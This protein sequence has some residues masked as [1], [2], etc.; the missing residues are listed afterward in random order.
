MIDLFIEPLQYPFMLKALLVAVTIS[1]VCGILSC[2]LIL[3]S[4]SLMGD[5]ISHAILPGIIIAYVINIPMSIGAFAS[6]LLCSL[7]IGYVKEKSRLKEDTV[8]GVVFSGFF[9]IG[10]ILFVQIK[11]DKHLD[12]I[13]LGNILG[14]TDVDMVQTLII[15]VLTF[16]VVLLKRKDFLLYCFDPIH[17]K[18]SGLSVRFTHY[19]LLSLLTITIVATIQSVGIILV[20]AMLVTPGITAFALSKNFSSMLII[21]IL[22]SILASIIGVIASF[23]LDSSTGPTIVLVQS[24]LFILSTIYIKTKKV[25]LKNDIT[26]LS[27]K[28]R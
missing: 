28:R 14:I 4:W 8:M 27:F 2:F 15:S 19:L 23:H 20:V 7:G 5:S 6:G 9:A 22:T 11:S 26:L 13:L 25:I 10:L 1:L 18:A 17:A 24:L 3:K 16:L 21:S 12:Q